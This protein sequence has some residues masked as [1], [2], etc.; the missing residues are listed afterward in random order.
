MQK[1]S[2]KNYIFKRRSPLATKKLEEMKPDYYGH[3]L[4]S[5]E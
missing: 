3:V 5:D 2:E 1:Y 4:L